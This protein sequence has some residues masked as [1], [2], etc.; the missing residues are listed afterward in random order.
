MIGWNRVTV[1]RKLH[2]LQERGIIETRKRD[3]RAQE[4]GRCSRG[5]TSAERYP[6]VSP[7]LFL[8][9]TFVARHRGL[10]AVFARAF[11]G[12]SGDPLR[13]IVITA[14]GRALFSARASYQATRS[15]A[16]HA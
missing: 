10:I 1:T 15:L 14:L 8:R 11:A 3:H 12:G 6:A 4:Y 2:D 16:P 5:E 7:E 13:G 9:L